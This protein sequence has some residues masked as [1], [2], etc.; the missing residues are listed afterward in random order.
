MSEK[1]K[2]GR[3]RKEA[4]FS[5]FN[6]EKKSKVDRPE[7]MSAAAKKMLLLLKDSRGKVILVIIISIISTVLSIV[8][9]VYLGDIIDTITELIKVKLTGQPLDLTRIKGILLTI[10]AIYAGSSLAGFFQH[11]IMAGINRDLVFTLRKKLNDK[12]SVLPLKYFDTNTKGDIISRVTNDIDNIQNT[13]QNNLIQILTS[14]ISVVGVFGI[15][16][17]ISPRM[18]LISLIVLPF[19][20]IIALFVL[21]ASRKY[22]RENWKT[23]GELNG[24]IE[25]MYSGH[26]IVRIFGH[27]GKAK[28]EFN[29]INHE[30]Y[31]IGRKAQFLSGILMPIVNFTSNIGYILICVF[32]G[33]YVVHGEMTIGEITV[34]IVYSKLF[35][36]PIVDISNIAN[37]LQSS[38]A[39]AER[40]FEVLEQEDEPEDSSEAHL[41][42][43][44]TGGVEIE[45]VNFSY[46][47]DKP[48]IKD[49]NVKVK[50]G[51]LVAL[52]G[53]TGAGKTTIVNLLMRF[54]DV[55][56]G[57]IRVDGTDITSVP[58][59][60]LRSVF[61]MVLQDTWLFEGSIR[62][63]IAYGRSDASFE[64]IVSAAKAAKA[65]HFINTLSEGYDTKLEEGA[66]NISQ[67]QR[68]LLTIARA[69]LADP[70]ILILDEATSSVDTRTELLI[71]KGMGNL[72]KNRTNFVIA[73]RLSTIRDADIILVMNDGRIIEQGTHDELLKNG[74]FYSE[75]YR[76]QFTG[77]TI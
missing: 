43:K 67:G 30:L 35:M 37:H 28:E 61:G 48:L 75:L 76:A 27:T 62:D 4:R 72:M 14:V 56:T 8:G 10:I 68:Q 38:L 66:S 12:L 53:P 74:G 57:C 64:E 55:N 59:E 1:T 52:V 40:V 9:P 71:Q 34:F 50:P 26:K 5:S 11:F 73:H 13:F 6:D 42:G 65:D 2:D 24:H 70:D 29:E 49:L 63:N 31:N 41:S 17:Y 51:Q 46:S 19:G 45:N 32:G 23:M 33:L 7:N 22:F 39:S 15:M 44:V 47:P 25:E 16:L 36:Q 21:K 54:Y 77:A 60:E 69:I 3:V 18:T 20:L 58:R